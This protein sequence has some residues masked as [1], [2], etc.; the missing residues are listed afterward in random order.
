[1]RQLP[2]VAD[3]GGLVA[4]TEFTFLCEF[5]Y[6]LCKQI[7]ANEELEQRFLTSSHHCN[8]YLKIVKYFAAQQNEI[9]VL[10]GRSKGHLF[11]VSVVRKLFNC[12]AKNV[13]CKVNNRSISVSSQKH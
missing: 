13:M 2:D 8:V 5:T 7:A 4:P 9:F 12:I 6:L 11:F 3:R 10:A 1:M